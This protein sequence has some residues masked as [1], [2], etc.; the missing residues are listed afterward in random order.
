MPNVKFID[1]EALKAYD[2]HIKTGFLN[3]TTAVAGKVDK[4][5]GMGLSHNDLTDDMV[6]TINNIS[7][8]EITL[9][10]E[11]LI[12]K[13]TDATT[14]KSGFMSSTDKT[15][16]D[17]IDATIDRAIVAKGYATETYVS[18]AI[19]NAVANGLK[20]ETVDALPTKNISDST[21]YLVP[22][23]DS[24]EGNVKDEYLH[25]T[26]GWEKIGSTSVDLT[27]YAKT[28]YVD[29]AITSALQVATTADI[30]ALFAVASE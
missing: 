12:N 1:L 14:T 5:E 17:G 8:G 7:G 26:A 18:T 13:P 25:L 9:D 15:K 20:F 11:K 28:A 27:E 24:V 16:L 2:E 21:I 6:Q 29:N 3:V 4:V 22:A 30:D 10:Y 23:T 19:T